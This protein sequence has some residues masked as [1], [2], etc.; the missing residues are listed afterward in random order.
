MITARSATHGSVMPAMAAAKGILM[1]GKEEME[2][3]IEYEI[4]K[5]TR[6]ISITRMDYNGIRKL[7]KGIL[8]IAKKHGQ[9]SE[10]QHPASYSLGGKCIFFQMPPMPEREDENDKT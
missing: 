7:I 5:L 8:E 3:P 9:A 4:S 1:S 2:T 10:C 6:E